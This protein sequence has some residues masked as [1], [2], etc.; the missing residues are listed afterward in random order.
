M[1]A[2][3]AKLV[4]LG[5]AIAAMGYCV[6]PCVFAAAP[7]YDAKSSAKLPEI[8]PALLAPT[9]APPPERNPFQAQAAT[10]VAPPARKKSPAPQGAVAG[11]AAKAAAGKAADPLGGLVLDATCISGSQRLA[12]ISGHIYR[13]QEKL[14]LAGTTAGPWLL[15]QVLP[16]K[17]L[18]ESQGKSVELKYSDR[19]HPASQQKGPTPA[20][21][22]GKAAGKARAKKPAASAAAPHGNAESAK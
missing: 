8:A 10:A 14:G 3:L 12:V 20:A 22:K 9:I 2:S 15:A 19:P 17:V 1:E 5:V 7:A 6:W 21:G 11:A 13:E 18:L 4:P 16:D